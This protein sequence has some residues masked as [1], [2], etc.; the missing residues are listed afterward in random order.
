MK[1]PGERGT[2]LGIPPRRSARGGGGGA[3]PS[4]GSSRQL[5]RKVRGAPARRALAVA[6]FGIISGTPDLGVLSPLVFRG[7]GIRPLRLATAM[8][9]VL[10]LT[11]R[12]N[13]VRRS[14]MRLPAS[15][16]QGGS[17]TTDYRDA[18][19][20]LA[21]EFQPNETVLEIC[22]DDIDF[23]YTSQVHGEAE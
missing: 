21:S 17:A 16:P 13:L 6:E 7:G 10:A 2:A 22:R 3:L 15:K 1:R 8:A 5:S 23:E 19:P 14:R 4:R 12:P 11:G 9:G 20:L 18:S